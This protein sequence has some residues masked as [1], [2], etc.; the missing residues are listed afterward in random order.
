MSWGTYVR[1]ARDETLPFGHRMRALGSLVELYRPIGFE[2]TFAYLQQQAGPIRD[3]AALLRAVDLICASR[4]AWQAEVRAYAARRRADKRRGRRTP[5]RGEANP[6]RQDRWYGDEATAAAVAL[7]VWLGRRL[8][9]ITAAG[10]D[11]APELSACAAV[12]A[13]PGGVLSPGQLEAL[14]RAAAAL[15]DGTAYGWQMLRV[16]QLIRTAQGGSTGRA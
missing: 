11:P 7:R 9:A 14:D 8:P 1:K 12:L 15:D 16:V 6:G 13:E 10:S 2:A 4:D 3:S 5:A